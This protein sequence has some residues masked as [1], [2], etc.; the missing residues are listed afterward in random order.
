[1]IS[2]V[3]P[4][5]NK[6]DYVL[7]AVNSLINSDVNNILEIIIVDD[8]SSDNSLSVVCGI[9]D[10]RIRVIPLDENK[11]PSNARNIGV[12]E[13]KFDYIFFLDADDFV[14]QDLVQNLTKLVGK[15]N[16]ACVNI[17]FVLEAS[18]C[19]TCKK[20]ASNIK[21]YKDAYHRFLLRNKFIF[22][23]SSTMI[24]KDIFHSLNGF[25]TKSNFTEDAEFW[26]RLSHEH[27]GVH[28]NETL[29]Y[30]RLVDDSLSNQ[31]I[32]GVKE[33]PILIL[34]LRKQFYDD[35]SNFNVSKAY[36]FMLLKY[37]V[38]ACA[39]DSKAV[40]ELYVLYE[41]DR[42]N[43]SKKYR[44]CFSF[45]NIVPSLIIRCIIGFKRYLRRFFIK[46]TV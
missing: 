30:Y 9:N 7:D 21:I 37:Y 12:R 33:L 11:G 28:V 16:F 40:N 35:M 26:A 41:A 22:T 39:T 44:V 27:E 29:S 10:E 1:M 42:N 36:A 3:I 18:C 46:Y 6:A 4:L 15:C 17:D 23:A 43:F 2:V 19:S 20:N 34:T 8:K 24:K 38:L 13:A 32:N 45:F 14:H 25:N 5:Y 31:F